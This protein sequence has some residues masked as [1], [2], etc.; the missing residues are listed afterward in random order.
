MKTQQN[1]IIP[2]RDGTKLAADVYIPDS[3]GPYPI[4]LER[5]PYNKENATMIWTNT[6]TYLAERGYMVVIQDTR[7]RF[8]SEGVWYPIR[9]DGWGKNQDGHDTVEWLAQHPLSNGAIGT[10]GGSYSGNTQYFMAPT[11]P[12]GLRCMFVRQ[13]CADLTEEWIYRGG[14]FELGL[15]LHW[16]TKESISALANRI[17]FVTR[18]VDEE[19]E[20]V[21]QDLPLLSSPVYTDPFQWLKDFL[22]HPP[23]DSEFW[24]KWNV[25]KQHDQIDVPIFHFGSWFDIFI[26][27]AI[28]NYVGLSKNAATEKARASQ[29]LYIGPWMHGPLVSEAFMKRVG[30]LD[31]GPE[32]VIDF[33]KL[34]SRWFDH[35][36]K[37]IDTGVSS[38]QPITIFVMGANTWRSLEGWPPAEATYHNYYLHSGFSGSASSLNDG[39]LSTIPPTEPESPDSFVYDPLHPTRTLGGNTLFALPHAQDQ[40][41]KGL[42]EAELHL[43]EAGLNA[44]PRDQRAVEGSCLTYTS[45]VLEDDVE[46]TGPVMVYLHA[47]SSAEDTDFVAKLTDV[48][49]DGRSILVTDGI[50]RARYRKSKTKTIPLKRGEADLFPIDLWATSNV[51]KKGHRIRVTIC[52]SNF[53]RYSRNLNI[54]K[55]DGRTEEAVVA[56]NTVYHDRERS[57]HIVLP[58]L[59]KAHHT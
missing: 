38:E 2:M 28:A 50:L 48:W 10:F 1:L 19:L 18:A 8:E 45:A 9:D 25:A 11:R 33:N 23:E 36:L 43:A 47:S 5:T 52:S 46:V 51:F 58:I 57:S 49:P 54:W 44:G 40:L 34:V 13:A 59:P 42:G 24:D 14:A 26:R 4:V 56:T 30:E 17:N 55:T 32:A 31:F 41:P 35:W 20:D 12:R 3:P 7:G 27:A 21:F 22:G 53:P 39:A 6:H 15:N 37:G 16:G 29:R